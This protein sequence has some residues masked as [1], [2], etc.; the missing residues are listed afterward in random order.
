MTSG[1]PLD[2]S[3]CFLAVGFA[4]TAAFRLLAAPAAADTAGG[5]SDGG[6][7][8]RCGGGAARPAD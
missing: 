1:T 2:A 4:H 8:G 5:L 7:G 3:F 6:G